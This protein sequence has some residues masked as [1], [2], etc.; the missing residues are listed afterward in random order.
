M[1]SHLPAPLRLLAGFS[2]FSWFPVN[3]RSGPSYALCLPDSSFCHIYPPPAEENSAFKGSC[4][5]TG[6]IQTV[7]DNLPILKSVT[8]IAPAKCL[9]PECNLF[10]HS[11]DLNMAGWFYLPSSSTF[12]S[13]LF[14]QH[15]FSAHIHTL[16]V[17]WAPY[18]VSFPM[19]FLTLAPSPALCCCSH[20]QLLCRESSQLQVL[21][22]QYL[23]GSPLIS[24]KSMPIFH[25][26]SEAPPDPLFKITTSGVPIMAQ[27]KRI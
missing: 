5:L 1:G 22:P 20:S 14:P 12:C 7:Q 10:P 6:P 27:R 16:T 26:R 18:T 24:S 9:W 2:G 13:H 17:P 3:S 15:L 8:L 21:L 19:A 25:L 11:R 23:R 4:V